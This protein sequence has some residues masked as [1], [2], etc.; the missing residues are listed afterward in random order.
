[1]NNKTHTSTF[2]PTA[3]QM[4]PETITTNMVQLWRNGVMITILSL[5]DAR[6]LVASGRC[7]CICSQAIENVDTK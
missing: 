2:T 3:S 6:A 1:M 7:Y 5:K 4:N